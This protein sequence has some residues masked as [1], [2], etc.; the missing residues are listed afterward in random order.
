M[1]P[2]GRLRAGAPQLQS[3]QHKVCGAG[4][5]GVLA[6]PCVCAGGFLAKGYG[7]AEGCAPAIGQSRWSR[8]WVLMAGEP[9]TAQAALGLLWDTRMRQHSRG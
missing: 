2:W 1:S 4:G 6:E 3:R 8:V 5:L 9:S 7:N